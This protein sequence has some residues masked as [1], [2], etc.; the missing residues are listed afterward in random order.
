M[1]ELA[2][3]IAQVESSTKDSAIRF[4]AGLYSSWVTASPN[5]ARD[6]IARTIRN[7]HNS[8][9]N[10]AR[11]IACTSWGRYQIL[12]ENIYSLCGCL[13]DVMGYVADPG[14]QRVCFDVFLQRRKIAFLLEDLIADPAKRQQF[15][16]TYNGPNAVEAYWGAM[17]SAVQVLGGS[18]VAD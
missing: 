8:S 10:T 18:V 1:I 4:E 17:K 3:V 5:P 11:M 12:G 9:N 13:R 7:I 16:S 2:D 6:T 15:I 14:Y